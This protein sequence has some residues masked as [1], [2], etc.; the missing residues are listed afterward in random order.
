MVTT[1]HSRVLVVDDETQIT[2]VLRT[3]LSAQGYDVRVAND[4]EMALEIMKDWAPNLVITDLAMPNLDGVGL[5]KRIRQTSQVPVIVLSVRG[6]DRVKVEA[7][8]AGADDYITKPFSV[9]ELLARV[10][11]RLR[12]A[13]PTETALTSITEGDFHIDLETRVVKVNGSE[14]ISL[15]RN[16]ICWCTWPGIPGR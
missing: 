15:R 6:Q 8:D 5:C 14:S 7:L 10:R 12:R 4:G 16:S 1:T 3:T 2:R 11:A 13:A 9:N